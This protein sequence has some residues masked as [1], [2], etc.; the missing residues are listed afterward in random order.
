MSRTRTVPVYRR[1]SVHKKKGKTE[2]YHD[3]MVSIVAGSTSPT[4]KNCDKERD[5][6]TQI[7]LGARNWPYCVLSHLETW[8]KFCFEFGNNG[9]PYVFG[10]IDKDDPTQ[11]KDS[12]CT[13]SDC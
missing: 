6:P 10:V 13:T 2:L 7:L 11:I 12:Q 4:T 5:A 8:L 1:R 3:E 9:N